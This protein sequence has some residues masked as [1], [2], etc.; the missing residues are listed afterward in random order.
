MFYA[1]QPSMLTLNG[2]CL[3][4]DKVAFLL[5]NKA[6]TLALNYSDSDPMNL[7]NKPVL[8]FVHGN[9][10]S[11]KVF[12]EQINLFS[13]KYRV[14]AIDL[15]GH[16]KSSKIYDLDVFTLEEK[17]SLSQHFYNPCS[18]I[19]QISQLL[20]TKEIVDAH[21]I[22]WGVGGC[23]AFGIAAVS[24]E[25]VA[26]ITTISSP[27]VNFCIEGFKKGF[28]EAFTNTLI[29]QW[30]SASEKYSQ[31]E[32]ESLATRLGFSESDQFIIEDIK[33]SDHLMRKHF[34]FNPDQYKNVKALE[35]EEFSKSTTIP[36][37]FIIA[38]INYSI[39]KEY[40]SSFQKYFKNEHSRI[41]LVK[42]S[43]NAIFKTNSAECAKLIE[44]FI[45]EQ[46]ANK[47]LKAY[48]M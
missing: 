22:A 43:K 28:S 11:L 37:C 33:S 24:P 12:E 27:P 7:D 10:C 14:I 39:N 15:L 38:E 25:I 17:N 9:Y 13:S 46:L 48:S 40:I 32:A 5:E 31:I 35:S 3:I 18:M 6:I 34:F 2:T 26:S 1:I 19:V 47:N 45:E 44:S 21:V 23:L 16:G 8:L 20:K 4:P 41:H 42:N 30:Q 36:L 29:P